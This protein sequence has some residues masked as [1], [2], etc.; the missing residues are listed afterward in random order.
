MQTVKEN[1][2]L[3]SPY[4][5]DVNLK[6]LNN[7]SLDV[8]SSDRGTQLSIYD[9]VFK[10]GY[11]K[12]PHVFAFYISLIIACLRK[13]IDLRVY[14]KTPLNNRKVDIDNMMK[15]I[16]MEKQVTSNGEY[17]TTPS[18]SYLKV[19]NTASYLF[20][21]LV[22]IFV[23]LF[24][25]GF[26]YLSGFIISITLFVIVYSII[27]YILW[28]KNYKLFVRHKIES[29]LVC[30]ICRFSGTDKCRTCPETKKK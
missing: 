23:V 12:F 7:I 13:N 9:T 8:T 30:K 25:L 27:K 20:L 22:T 28:K 14:N 17:Y 24:L 1:F 26:Y 6:H 18:I 21:G 16:K 11:G 19:L 3:H 5:K 29:N 2:L 4:F 15:A 10:K